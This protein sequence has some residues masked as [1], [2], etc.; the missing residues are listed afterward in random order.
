MHTSGGSGDESCSCSAIQ[1]GV[2]SSCSDQI[3]FR[4]DVERMGDSHAWWLKEVE[5]RGRGGQLSV[6]H[7]HGIMT[8]PST[9]TLGSRLRA[10]RRSR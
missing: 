4:L 1:A 10:A 9:R 8:V 3:D 7:D 5:K 6:G 2:A